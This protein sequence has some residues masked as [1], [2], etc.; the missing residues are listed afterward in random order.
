M[1]PVIRWPENTLSLCIGLLLIVGVGESV[2]VQ[3]KNVYTQMISNESATGAYSMESTSPATS[4]PTKTP[5]APARTTPTEKASG[6]S[7]TEVASH[8]SRTS[9]WS[10]INGNVYDL[11]S[12][13]P[14][15]PGGE[16]AIL[17]LCGK[18]GSRKFNG[19]H[20][21]DSGKLAILSG[22]KIGAALK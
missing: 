16:S 3:H 10:T 12:W 6:I 1:V 17:G 9:C 14:K 5:A 7:A 11:T 8:A 13:I 21:G 15:H 18:D 2:L 4:T 20:G 22:F 19:Q